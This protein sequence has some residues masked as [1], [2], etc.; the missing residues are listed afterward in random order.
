[1]VFRCRQCG[2]CCSSMGEIIGIREQTGEG[3][4]LIGFSV[5]GEERQVRI[6][7]DK[8]DLF[9]AQDILKKRPMGC[10]FLREREDGAVICTVHATRPEL[11]RQ[12]GCFRV[13]VTGPGGERLGRVVDGSRYFTTMDH[14]LR[15]LWDREIV[16]LT[17]ADEIAWEEEVDR[18]LSAE[19]YRVVR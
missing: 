16:P 3:E 18:I 13:L 6:D 19:G 11:C 12:Y 10:P 5:T 9:R 8:Q 2:E 17:I 1:M 7:P 15:A 14:E 4:Y